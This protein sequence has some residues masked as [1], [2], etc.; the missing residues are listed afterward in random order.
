MALHLISIFVHVISALFWIG[1]MLFTAAV[2]VPASRD[3][4]LA[5]KRGAFF[6]L[7]GQRF[8]RIV[9]IL[10]ALIFVTGLTNLVTKGFDLNVLFDTSFYAS[11]YG[12]FIGYKLLFFAFVL[13]ISAFHDFFFGP[14]ASVMID[15]AP[16]AVKTMRLRKVTSWLG[17]VNLL[18]GLVTLFFALRLLRG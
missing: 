17:R 3:K 15:T 5:D 2:L 18:L 12:M 10:F 1:G 14:K 9:W 8:S 13:G 7:I 11:D 6:T 4:L 16:D